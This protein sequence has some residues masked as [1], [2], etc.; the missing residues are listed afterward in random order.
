MALAGVARLV[1]EDARHHAA[2]AVR[3]RHGGDLTAREHEVAEADLLVHARLDEALVH[4]LIVPA[5]QNEL[6]I[7]LFQP[8]R[9]A[10]VEG[11]ALRRHVDHAA[12]QTLRIG[13][14]G[15]E[16]AFQGLG[17]HHLTPAAAV[18]IVVHLLLAVFGVVAD[19][20]TANVQNP[21]CGRA[22]EDAL[23]QHGAHGIGKER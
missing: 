11:L 23:A 10:L 3:H 22:A 21:L 19:L 17:V 7:V 1:R 9:L 13:A 8:A 18:G 6:V 14:G 5:D 12:A 4:A 16:A 2:D 15:V 20:V